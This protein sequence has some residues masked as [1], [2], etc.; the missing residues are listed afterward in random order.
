MNKINI[1]WVDDEIDRAFGKERRLMKQ[2]RE[3]VKVLVPLNLDGFLLSHFFF[4]A[5]LVPL[6][7]FSDIFL[8]T[9]FFFQTANAAKMT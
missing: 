5:S 8:L 6:I 7:F 4:A 2:R 3:K 1:L 9:V